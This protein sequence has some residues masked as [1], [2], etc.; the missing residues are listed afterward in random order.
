MLCSYDAAVEFLGFFFYYRQWLGRSNL[1]SNGPKIGTT[2]GCQPKD[3][4]FSMDS[5]VASGLVILHCCNVL[6]FQILQCTSFLG[7]NGG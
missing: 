7:L 1:Q 6:Y 4:G 3:T 5:V 2:N